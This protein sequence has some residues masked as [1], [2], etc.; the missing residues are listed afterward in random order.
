MTLSRKN[1]ADTN[2]Q[3]DFAVTKYMT[4]GRENI[5]IENISAGK[6]LFRPKNRKISV[7]PKNFAD[8]YKGI[9]LFV[10]EVCNIRLRIFSSIG[11]LNYKHVK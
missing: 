4:P 1:T 10:F 7:G 11:I 2:S 5:L 9:E 3:I 8:G 6:K